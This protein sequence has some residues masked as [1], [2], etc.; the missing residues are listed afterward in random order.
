MSFNKNNLYI[1]WNDKLAG[2]KGWF[3]DYLIIGNDSMVIHNAPYGLCLHGDDVLPFQLEAEDSISAWRCFYLDD[4]DTLKYKKPPLGLIPKKFFYEKRLQDIKE[5]I[6]RYISDS[7]EIPEEWIKEYNSI[8]P[9]LE[10]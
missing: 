1:S 4:E 6:L 8:I 7:K 5:A 10:N 2:R 9:V 3:S